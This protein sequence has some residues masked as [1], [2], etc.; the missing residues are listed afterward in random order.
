MTVTSKSN[1]YVKEL[2]KLRDK[3]YRRGSGTFLVEGA[4]SVEECRA[5]GWEIERI[6]CTE[7]F[8]NAYP[9]AFV[10]TE[11]VFKAISTEVSPQGVAAV[12]KIKDRVFEP[13]SGPCIF[14]DRLQDPGNVGTIIRTAYAAGFDEI[15]LGDCADCYS[16]KVVQASMGG[17]FKT[18]I[19]S[20]SESEALEALSSVPLIVADMSGESIFSFDPPSMYCLCIGNEGNGVSDELKRRAASVVSV[21]MREGCESL[22]A[23]I[24]AGICMYE[25]KN[26]TR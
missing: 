1:P 19:F 9:D 7:K 6:V 23:A 26:K 20:G 8:E 18:K 11:D 4:K 22:N 15:Y 21:P 12:V 14:L 3:K 13:P 5:F 17:I 25:L 16:P 24:C 10:V 2:S